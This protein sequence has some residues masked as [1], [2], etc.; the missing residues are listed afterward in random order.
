M[1]KYNL[2]YTSKYRTFY[3][4]EFEYSVENFGANHANQY[5]DKI[6]EMVQNLAHNPKLYRDRGEFRV[7][8][9]IDGIYVM[10]KIND[11]LKAITVLDIAG[12]SRY[13]ALI[14]KK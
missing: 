3:Q 2:V 5:F 9:S 13:L 6:D 11:D 12:N 1:P 14:N 7:A 10:Y 4:I 8:N